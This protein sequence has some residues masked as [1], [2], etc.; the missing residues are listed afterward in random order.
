MEKYYDTDGMN[1]YMAL[2]NMELISD[3]FESGMLKN[4]H[5]EYLADMEIRSMN[6]VDI[7]Y[8]DVSG[9]TELSS[10]SGS[11]YIEPEMI[12]ALIRD[13]LSA[14]SEMN[15]YLLTVNNLMLERDFIF[16]NLT[17]KRFYFIYV[18][19]YNKNI[20]KQI[21]SLLEYFMQ[22]MNHKNV[23]AANFVYDLYEK[24]AEDNWDIKVLASFTGMYFKEEEEAISEDAIPEENNIDKN[25][26]SFIS[27]IKEDISDEKNLY[28]LYKVALIICIS[29]T[30]LFGAAN[31]YMQNSR[32]GQIN[33][34][35]P[36]IGVLLILA[37]EIFVYLEIGMYKKNTDDRSEPVPEEAAEEVL[38]KEAPEIV[39]HIGQQAVST[40]SYTYVLMPYG[41]NSNV[42]IYLNR[43]YFL[44]GRDSDSGCFLNNSSI[45][46]NHAQIYE[47]NNQ[48]VVEDL[49]STNGTYVNDYPVKAGYPAVILPGDIVRFGNEEYQIVYI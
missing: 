5:I 10:V 46:R 26:R 41:K 33:N 4:N 25:Q 20:R 49:N 42:P 24:C 1:V 19:G 21:K 36:L 27:D 8:Y 28:G 29:I 23:E 48:L 9:L 12:I 44:I 47:L 7:P 34:L 16:Y 45:S 15:S 39:N 32:T 31:L 17:E 14:L 6:G 35:K 11:T 37:A 30:L 2:Y 22:A 40:Y 3:N 13:V 38:S 43:Q 18:P